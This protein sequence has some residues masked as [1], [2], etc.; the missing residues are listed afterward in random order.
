MTRK[1]ILMAIF[2]KTLS[3]IIIVSDS[4]IKYVKGWEISDREPGLIAKLIVNIA[5]EMKNKNHD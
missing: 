3:Y 2:T 1:I 4:M 5:L